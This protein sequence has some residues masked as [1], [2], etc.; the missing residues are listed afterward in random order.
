[1]LSVN[2][3]RVNARLISQAPTMFELLHT[4]CIDGDLPVEVIN[5]IQSIINHVSAETS[6]YTLEQ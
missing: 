1:V 2:S 4:V 3:Q 5:Q 6:T